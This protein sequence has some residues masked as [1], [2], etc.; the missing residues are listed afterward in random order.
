[1]NTGKEQ[2]S[3]AGVP[4][5]NIREKADPRWIMH[6]NSDSIDLEVTVKIHGKK[7]HREKYRFMYTTL[8]EALQRGYIGKGKRY[9]DWKP[10]DGV[11]AAG[12]IKIDRLEETE[13][14]LI[15]HTQFGRYS[16]PK[17][18]RA[19]LPSESELL[20]GIRVKQERYVSIKDDDAALAVMLAKAK[21]RAEPVPYKPIISI[22]RRQYGIVGKRRPP[23]C[24]GRAQTQTASNALRSTER[25]G[26]RRPKVSHAKVL[27]QWK[28]KDMVKMRSALDDITKRFTSWNT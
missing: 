23:M 28:K 21:P 26:E 9:I 11:K 1:M 8:E 12:I 6:Q 20:F 5:Y 16:I 14:Y 18:L 7:P 3:L 4:W 17:Y 13:K 19:K 24:V 25:T 10:L 22:A 27:G 15:A 2:D